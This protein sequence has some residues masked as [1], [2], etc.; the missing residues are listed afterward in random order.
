M[1]KN[2]VI[3]IVGNPNC[4]KS[5][6]F[7]QLTGSRQRVGNWPGVTVERKEG[8]AR[9]EDVAVTIVDLPGV[10]TLAAQSPDEKVAR[11]FVLSGDYDLIVNILDAANLER[12]LYLTVQLMEMRIPMLVVLNMMDMAREKGLVV[13]VAALVAGLGCRVVPV[14]AKRREGLGALMSALREIA[15]DP[16]AGKSLLPLA[17]PLPESLARAVGA[18]GSELAADAAARNIDPSWVALK[19]LEGDGGGPEPF[20][21]HSMGD[22]VN[23]WH[24]SLEEEMGDEPDILIADARYRFIGQM[25]LAAIH[26]KG[27]A[28]HRLTER[29]DRWAMHRVLGIPIFL[30]V[31]YLMFMF[32][33]N[34][35]GAF[36][37]FFDILFGA[38]FV[39]GPRALLTPW[40][41]PEWLV[42]LL[43]DG[44]GGSIQ[45][46][47]T[48]IPPIGFMFIFLSWLEDSG[49]MG[50]AAFILDRFL[51]FIGLPGKAFI[52]M[53][54]GFGCN[55]PAIL[56]TR[57]LEHRR[58]RILTV[59]MNPFMS[60]GA[61]MPVYAL[62]VAAFF[63]MGGQNVV[64]GL[65]LAGVAFAI[66]TGLILR[67]TLLQGE[68]SPF[69]MELPLYHL[70][71]MRTV[72]F[73]AW[74][75]LK[76]FITRAGRV[77]I[78]VIM[79]LS[80]LNSLGVDGSFGNA[81]SEKSVLSHIGRSITPAFSP[82]GIEEENWPATVGLFIGIFAKEAVVGA[83]DAVYGQME[84]DGA[85]AS[86]EARS[87]FDLVQRVRDA[88]S[89]IVD[90]L[91]ELGGTVLDPLGVSVDRFDSLEDAASATEVSQGTFGTMARLF[92]GRVGA[93]A[94]LLFILLYLPCV[95]AISAIFQ[96]TG[97]RWTLFAGF[98]TTGLAWSAA[99]LFY[100]WGTFSRHPGP[101]FLWTAALLTAWIVTILVMRRL[102][103]GRTSAPVPNTVLACEEA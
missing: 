48:F 54:V 37:D 60:C 57:T 22:Q 103:T 74:E 36:I 91:G 46:L 75:R 73:H 39:E 67:H 52:P 101:T 16:G 13:D 100:Q 53:M 64:F 51:R 61:R 43:A 76:G 90:H 40:G 12:N 4:G 62:F 29:L 49:Y 87:G 98:W 7:N 70:P 45:T 28:S 94:Y 97:W 65:Y 31:L 59:M 55:V 20:W 99:T 3:G 32:T 21:G 8:V 42:T 63:P 89:S 14:V 18:L 23:R 24:R 10:Y 83:L 34:L 26:R 17:P 88:V 92:D 50:R 68:P 38:V 44:L 96:E 33:I 72:S 81:D 6:L 84:G 19:L 11:D 82:M 15:L 5:T 58:D 56:G 85:A 77:L 30:G 2:L 1:D 9:I 78:P 102:G 69:I 93:V 27:E 71:S 79:A 80:F 47:A 86:D 95:A 66:F 35:G 25:T 41:T